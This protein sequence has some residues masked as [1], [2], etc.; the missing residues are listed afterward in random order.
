M[1]DVRLSR[2]K[3]C[4]VVDDPTNK[5]FLGDSGAVMKMVPLDVDEFVDMPFG[6]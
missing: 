4:G 1:V 2:I 6:C 5:Q 3:R